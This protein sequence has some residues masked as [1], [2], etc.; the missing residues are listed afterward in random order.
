M[1]VTTNY[2]PGY[3]SGFDRSIVKDMCH[4]EPKNEI[5]S[6][7][8]FSPFRLGSQQLT[9][10]LVALPVYTGYAYPDGR[11]SPQL[12]DH[13]T[14]LA[15]SGVAMV[16]VA[17]A[18]ISSDGITSTYNLRVD[19]DEYIPGLAR[20]AKAIRQNGVIAC[21]QLNHAGRFAKTEQ[22]L[23]PS[24]V[25]SSNL[26]FNIEVLKDFMNFFP[27]EKRFKLTRQF[28]KQAHRWRQSMTAEDRERIIVNFGEAAA[29]AHQAGFDMIELHGANGY[30]ICE[31]LSP[32]TNKIQHGFG[33]SFQERTTFPLK[34]I[35]EIKR[36]VTPK[37]PIG[38]RL[39]LREWVPGGIKLPEAIA[40]AKLLENEGI[41]YLSA[42]EGTVNSIFFGD[43]MK[44]ISRPA[45]LRKD[46]EKLTGGIKVPT[47]ISGRIL[48]PS[49]ANELIREKTA[50]LIGLG[51]PLRVDFNWAKKAKKQ[52]PK[53]IS[54]TN[55]N[56][57]LK[58][59]VLDQG[60][61]C[62][63]WPKMIQQRTDL[64]HQLLTRNYKGLWVITDHNDL[65]LFKAS[66]PVLLPDGHHYPI[67]ISP[68][69]FFLNDVSQ[70]K[71]PDRD[72]EM[73]LEWWIPG[74][75]SA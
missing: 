71:I 20:L 48:G 52:N 12:I 42:T 62:R 3:D 43:V 66:L 7:T 35:K 36:K 31:F 34:V 61:S 15:Q 16:V 68:T 25:D 73:F 29:R 32:F 46:M 23:L 14:K 74:S 17:N 50:D 9:N 39:M 19:R 4:T 24:P 41:A 40:F 5:E 51:R 72:R 38:F 54:C 44:K 67:P 37:F 22:P 45:Y 2:I 58:R 10:R 49:L 6:P 13:Y 18:A 21:L 11:V 53:I 27:L 56:W 65:N 47:I 1:S 64:D 8:I 57:C 69:I 26:A 70:N 60:F 75:I 28:L 30:L 59:V 63:R 55:C 33:G